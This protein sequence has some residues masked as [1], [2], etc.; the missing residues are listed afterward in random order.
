MLTILPAGIL[1]IPV[2]REIAKC[3]W[4]IAYKDILAPAQMN[5]MLDKLYSFETL[6]FQHE[7]LNFK[8]VLALDEDVP[9]GFATWSPKENFDNIYRLHK[10]YILPD[11]QSKGTGRYL[12]EHVISEIKTRNATILELNV[13][14][15]NK[16]RIFYE[17]FGFVIVG[18][19]D[20][21]IGN[22]YFMNDYVMKKEL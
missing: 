14:R 22:G 13:N 12:L 17:K 5:Y 8:S 7:Q 4:Q 2:I 19:E 6:Q 3:S 10:I 9:V 15:Q 11:Q 21:P 18:E 20:I 16:A 1:E